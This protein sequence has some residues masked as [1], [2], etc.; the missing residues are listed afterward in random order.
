MTMMMASRL[1]AAAK[2]VAAASAVLAVL[3]P[4]G[5][6][7]T[8]VVVNSTASHSIPKLLC[9]YA[10][11]MIYIGKDVEHRCVGGQMFEDINVSVSLHELGFR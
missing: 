8:T 3:A 9:E 1:S 5:R 7:A 2:F 10:V 11:V 4:V 6:A